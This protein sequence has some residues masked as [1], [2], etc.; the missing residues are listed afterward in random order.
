MVYHSLERMGEKKQIVETCYANSCK[1]WDVSG[2]YIKKKK[3]E[4][5]G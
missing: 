4:N 2:P 1:G 3:R 5:L